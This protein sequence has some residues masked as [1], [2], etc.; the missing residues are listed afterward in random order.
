[1]ALLVPVKTIVVSLVPSPVIKARPVVPASVSVPLV[2]VSV[3]RNE[4]APAS[5]SLTLIPLLSCRGKHQR[6]ILGDA[7]R[8]GNAVDWRV[9]AGRYSDIACNRSGRH[10][11][12]R[13]D[14]GHGA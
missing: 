10:I 9:V 14:E 11:A 13:R 3:M 4:F 5:A 6:R 1:M 8:P 7:L 12:V 2:T